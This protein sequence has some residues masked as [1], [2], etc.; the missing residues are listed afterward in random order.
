MSHAYPVFPD[1]VWLQVLCN[2]GIADRMR[3]R[4]VCKKWNVLVRCCMSDLSLVDSSSM[5]ADLQNKETSLSKA[6]MMNVL[7]QVAKP[8]KV[9]LNADRYL[10]ST[11]DGDYLCF[12]A[13]NAACGSAL[14]IKSSEMKN[15]F[16]FRSFENLDYLCL[17]LE[18]TPQHRIH[19]IRC[20]PGVKALKLAGDGVS[21]FGLR[22]LT[23][24]FP[25]DLRNLESL[26]ISL[27][28]DCDIWEQ[29]SLAA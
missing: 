28:Y 17:Q 7:L 18:T 27:A 14:Y 8:G 6:E 21:A 9:V 13:E 29:S 11:D 25:D 26:Y 4:R 1:A 12:D 5:F 19:G 2:L 23:P 10:A 20:P 15:F 16:D 24:S 22:S 3:A